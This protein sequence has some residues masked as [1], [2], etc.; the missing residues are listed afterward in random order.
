MP[1]ERELVSSLEN[2]KRVLVTGSPRSGTTWTG[3]MIARAPGMGYI[4]EPFTPDQGILCGFANPLTAFQ[5][6]TDENSYRAK[7]Y[8]EN[9][10][11]FKY[12]FRTNVL[13]SKSAREAAQMLWVF[14]DLSFHRLR[15]STAVMKDPLAVFSAPWLARHFDMNVVVTIR[16]PAAVC[17]S[18]KVLNWR[19]DFN[20]LLSQTDLMRDT[21][22]ADFEAEIRYF[23]ENEQE[24]L[25]QA[26]LLWNCIYTVV[27]EYRMYY[28]SWLFVKHEELS[29]DP[30]DSFRKIYAELGL[31][32]TANAQ[33][34]IEEST[35]GQD[36]KRRMANIT[37][38]P[39]EQTREDHFSLIRNSKEN[40][41][42]WR[43]RLSDRE[44]LTIRERTNEVAKMFYSDRDW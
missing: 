28:P 42:S 25:L 22:L 29:M 30:I 37:L 9:L 44:I 1:I 15:R 33:T 38:N 10:L 24:I 40:V 26:A 20:Y 43:R 14:K 18:M 8:L 6:I 11:D 17:S 13:H 5:Y 3:R 34:G 19:F 2:R 4:H 21:R 41:S 35:S 32:F 23:A 39:F 7:K 27:N 31:E 12:P 16:H 36:S